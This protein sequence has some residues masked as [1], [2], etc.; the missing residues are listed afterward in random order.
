MIYGLQWIKSIHKIFAIFREFNNLKAVLK[1]YTL[2]A[3]K[4]LLY[5]VNPAYSPSYN[6][7]SLDLPNS[8]FSREKLEKRCE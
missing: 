2:Q 6:G 8:S 1:Q 7:K 5:L 3:V 4:R